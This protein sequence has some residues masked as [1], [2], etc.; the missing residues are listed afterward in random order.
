MFG[1]NGPLCINMYRLCVRPFKK[2]ESSNQF[3]PKNAC[4]ISFLYYEFISGMLDILTLDGFGKRVLLKD[5]ADVFMKP[6]P[7]TITR[8]DPRLLQAKVSYEE[9]HTAYL[10]KPL[11]KDWRPAVSF[12]NI[13]TYFKVFFLFMIC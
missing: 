1:K 10:T 4:T 9:Y 2:S 6:H 7:S 8:D 3:Y 11:D 13:V 5:K 12:S